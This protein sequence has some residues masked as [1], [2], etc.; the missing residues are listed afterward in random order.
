MIMR[1]I[2]DTGKKPKRDIT[3]NRAHIVILWKKLK[4]A[5]YN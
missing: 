4:I 5:T 1:I 2:V 3:K